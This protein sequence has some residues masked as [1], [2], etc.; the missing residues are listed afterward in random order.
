MKY[1]HLVK[2][3]RPLTKVQLIDSGQGTTLLQV[4]ENSGLQK[5]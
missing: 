2:V 1:I 5:H 4:E 3:P